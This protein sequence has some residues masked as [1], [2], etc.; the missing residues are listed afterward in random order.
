[1]ILR[2]KKLGSTED[3]NFT[4]RIKNVE[5][6]YFPRFNTGKVIT[7]CILKLGKVI[8]SGVSIRGK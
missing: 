2:R 4:S 1:M 8:T 7:F 5:S 3:L 6:N